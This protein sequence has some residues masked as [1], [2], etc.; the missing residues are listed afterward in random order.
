MHMWPPYAQPAWHA[1]MGP[2]LMGPV[3]RIH[4]LS[5]HLV[6]PAHVSTPDR[7]AATAFASQPLSPV[8]SDSQIVGEFAKQGFV[9]VPSFFSES[10]LQEIEEVLADFMA[11]DMLVDPGPWEGHCYSLEEEGDLST[12]WRIGLNAERT[13]YWKTLGEGRLSRLFELC[14][15]TPAAKDFG[16]QYFDKTPGG[17]SRPTPPHQDGGYS[18]PDVIKQCD[19]EANCVIVLDDMNSTNG[20][21]RYVPG[22]HLEGLREHGVG[23][24]SFSQA[25]PALSDDD[26]RREVP[27]VAKRG[28]VI[29][30]HCLVIHRADEN[31]SADLHRRTI[32][33]SYASTNIEAITSGERNKK[34]LGVV[35]NGKLMHPGESAR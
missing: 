34:Q 26:L 6:A 25:I 3:R 9:V 7:V 22:S 5:Q 24:V 32:G 27:L 28:D 23:V 19:E 4:R 1:A 16:L 29:A 13:P 35:E 17:Q 12:V 18:N 11:G 8:L 21:L 14:I 10:Q 20:C 15:G 31:R 33:Y 30:H 2:A